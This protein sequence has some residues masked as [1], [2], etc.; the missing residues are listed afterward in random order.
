MIGLLQGY[1]ITG[2][3]VQ[4]SLYETFIGISEMMT[5]QS[6]RFAGTSTETNVQF[7]NTQLP[8]DLCL[9]PLGTQRFLLS[10]SVVRWN[11]S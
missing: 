10:E 1:I 9:V 8:R 3:M 4:P 7:P 11:C 6:A 2:Q 5:V